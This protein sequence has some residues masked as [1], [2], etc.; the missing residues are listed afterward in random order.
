MK[1]LL[2]LLVTGFLIPAG[3][4]I[5]SQ[6]DRSKALSPQDSERIFYALQADPNSTQVVD[7]MLIAEVYNDSF[8]CQAEST[9]VTTPDTQ[10]VTKYTCWKQ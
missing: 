8:Y 4:A 2:I 7:S 1:T 5:N 3:A 9:P 6:K 10:S